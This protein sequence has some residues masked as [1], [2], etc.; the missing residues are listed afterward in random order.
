M[1]GNA[2]G[3]SASARVNIEGPEGGN[4]RLIANVGTV[5]ASGHFD[6]EYRGPEVGPGKWRA[7]ITN[8]DG[9]ECCRSSYIQARERKGKLTPW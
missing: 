9:A 7:I 1:I 4:A 3:C 6:V 8:L 5:Q 2:V